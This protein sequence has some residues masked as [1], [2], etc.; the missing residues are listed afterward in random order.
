MVDRSTMIRVTQF[1]DCHFTTSAEPTYGG[2][3]YNTTQAWDAIFD[4]TFDGAHPDLVV[5]TGE[6]A[7]RGRADEYEMARQLLGRIPGPMNVAI[8]NHDRHDSFQAFNVHTY[9]C[10]STTRR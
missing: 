4:H 5:V 6:I 8:G 7:D 1:S 3:G 2:L 9:L 10:G